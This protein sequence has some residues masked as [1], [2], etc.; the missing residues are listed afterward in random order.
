MS[1]IFS[2]GDVI[3]V[4]APTP[5]LVEPTRTHRPGTRLRVVEHVEAQTS[6]LGGAYYEA[7]SP[8]G[9]RDALV[10]AE[11]AVLVMDA[12]AAGARTPP[13]PRAVLEHLAHCALAG[14]HDD[15]ELDYG[16][17][18]VDE[19]SS[20]AVL[21]LGGTTAAGLVFEASVHI[22]LVQVTGG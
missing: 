8:E 11:A 9:W 6:Q 18:H 5:D 12:G 16:H 21:T 1:T 3:T 7:S 4:A 2:E 10:P 20:T 14:A 17:T 22:S 13:A 15:F 19:E